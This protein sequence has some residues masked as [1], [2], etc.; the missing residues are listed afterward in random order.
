MAPTAL[1]LSRIRRHTSCAMEN[2]DDISEVALVI[3]L[4]ALFTT[5]LQLLQQFYATVDGYRRCQY[6]IMGGW[7]RYTYR[8]FRWSQFIFETLFVVPEITFVEKSCGFEDAVNPDWV[9]EEGFD[10]NFNEEWNNREYAEFL[11]GWGGEGSW[12]CRPKIAWRRMLRG[13]KNDVL[14]L[15]EAGN[16]RNKQR[17]LEKPT[18]SKPTTKSKTDLFI[19]VEPRRRGDWVCWVSMMTEIRTASGFLKPNDFGEILLE[20]RHGNST[21]FSSSG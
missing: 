8:R 9:A 11:R 20:C 2:N 16:F 18:Y 1:R 19:E 6:P 13:G 17:A 5:L 15:Q 7:A 14:S 21:N 10:T 12:T 4:V 3:S